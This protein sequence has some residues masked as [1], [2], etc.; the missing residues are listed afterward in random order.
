MARGSNPASA[1]LILGQEGRANRKEKVVDS[2]IVGCMFISMLVGGGCA[3]AALSAGWGPLAGLAI[4]SAT[5][6]ATLVS[7]ALLA[8]RAP[9]PRAKCRPAA[10]VATA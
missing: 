8:A 1:V 5:G 2:K 4:Y 7:T 3:A 9:T 6:S 10:A